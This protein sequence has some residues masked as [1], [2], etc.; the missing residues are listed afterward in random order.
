MMTD[1]I[2]DMLTR[3]RNA[4]LANQDRTDIPLSKL[5]VN[6]A[7]ILKQEG[8]VT[9]Y[10]VGERSLTVHMKYG[11]G[12]RCAFIGIRRASRPGRRLYVGS[13]D[14]PKVHNGLGVAIM[15]TSQGLMTDKRAREINVGGEVLCE[16]W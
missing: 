4:A 15:S 13:K 11:K 12:R 3:L 9:D 7:K 8:Y 2:A 14:I 6:V 1:P 16:V 10:E 5:K